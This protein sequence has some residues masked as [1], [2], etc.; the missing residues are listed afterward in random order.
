[1]GTKEER[2][3]NIELVRILAMCGVVFMHYCNPGMGGV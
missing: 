2:Q 3:V 1:M